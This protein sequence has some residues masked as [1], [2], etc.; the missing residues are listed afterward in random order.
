MRAPSLALLVL[1]TP[2]VA[3][4]CEFL[5]LVGID[6]AEEKHGD[7]PTHFAGKLDDVVLEVYPLGDGELHTDATTRL[8]FIVDELEKVVNALSA[9]G[10]PTISPPKQ[11]AW[12]H[13]AVVKDPDGRRIELYQR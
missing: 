7:G 3:S 1:K 5:R 13:R 4:V 6:L 8:G 2:N 11:T 9:A 10:A 12:G